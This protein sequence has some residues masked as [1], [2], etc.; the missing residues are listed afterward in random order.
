MHT[1]LKGI[2]E[3]ENISATKLAGWCKIHP[4]SFRRMLRGE[5]KMSTEVFASAME[6]LGYKIMIVKK[7]DIV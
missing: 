2:M 1:T 3:R 5:L 6:Q 7:E 4:P